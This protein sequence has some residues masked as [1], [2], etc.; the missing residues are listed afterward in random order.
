MS[1]QLN[2]DYTPLHKEPKDTSVDAFAKVKRL[3]LSNQ[4][5]FHLKIRGFYGATNSEL[6]AIIGGNP[7]SIQPRTADLS[8]ASVPYVQE[9]PDGVKRKNSYDNDEIVWVLTPAGYEHYKTL[10]VR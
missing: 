4:V 5:I 7:N 10:E 9:H 1:S 2:L 3:T 6:V 8:R